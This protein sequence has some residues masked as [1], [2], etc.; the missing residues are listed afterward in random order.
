MR[1][2]VVKRKDHVVYD[3]IEEFPD[4]MHY[5]KDWK[6][7]DLGDWVLADDGCII[8]I[9]RVGT[10]AKPKGKIR[11]LKYVGTCTGTFLCREGYSMDCDRRESIYTLSGKNPSTHVNERAEVTQR[12]QL[13]AQFVSQ[14]LDKTEAYLRAYKT[15]KKGYAKLQA[16][17]LLKQ[18]RVRTAMKESLKPV[19]DQLGINDNFVL[20]GIKQV[21]QDG[22]K[23]ADRLRALFELADILEMKESKKE[24]TAIGAAMFKGFLP[25]NTEIIEE[26]KKM[27]EVKTDA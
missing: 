11:T 16:G 20:T 2:Y 23:D 14:G 9:L 7:G 3:S 24:I 12:E 27:I 21:A 13:F 26:R 5:L 19:L 1:T 8:Q 6:E 15:D 4:T 22:E 18:E 10:F 17:V 25:E